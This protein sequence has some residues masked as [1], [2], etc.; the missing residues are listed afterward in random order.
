M[1]NG[2]LIVG[3]SQ[4]GLQ[5]AVSLRQLGDTSPIMLIGEETHPP[6][7]RPPLSKE[8]LAG[9]AELDSLAF[10]APA[11]YADSGIDLVCGERVTGVSLS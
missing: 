11:F 3:G 6:Y 7:Q 8:F 5:L 10:R 1:S 4:A 9:Q 2:T